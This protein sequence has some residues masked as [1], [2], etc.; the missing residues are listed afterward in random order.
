MHRRCF[1]EDRGPNCSAHKLKRTPNCHARHL[2]LA[3]A[4]LC[5]RARW[6]DGDAKAA[7][8]T[9][10][11]FRASRRGSKTRLAHGRCPCSSASVFVFYTGFLAKGPSHC[12]PDAMPEHLKGVRTAV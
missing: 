7:R 6:C 2:V 3:T 10:A 1:F 11:I 4:N 9:L 12:K 5:K 8:D